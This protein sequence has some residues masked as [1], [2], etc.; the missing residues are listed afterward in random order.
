MAIKSMELE[1]TRENLL[2][3]LSLDLLDRNESVWHFACFCDAQEDRCSIA[4]DAPWGAGKTFFIRHVQ[5]LMDSVNPFTAAVT[6]EERDTIKSAFLR[7]SN[8]SDGEIELQKE[9]CVYYDAWSNDNEED[10]ILSL[11]YEIIK[12]S[13]QYVQFK[14]STDYVDVV[15]SMVDFFT[16]KNTIEFARLLKQKDLLAETKAKKEIHSLVAEFLDSLLS[17]RGDR[18]IVFIDELD[19]CKPEFAVRL[20]ERIKHYFANVRITFVFSVNLDELQHTVRR[21]YGEGFDAFRYLDRFFDYRIALPPANMTKYYQKIGLLYEHNW[22]ESVCKSVIDYYGFSLREIEKF[23]RMAKVAAHK[24]THSQ[25][26]TG[27]ADG[28]ALN[29]SLI[30]IVPIIIGLHMYNMDMYNEFITGKNPQPLL[31]IARYCG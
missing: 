15:S 17:E 1:P 26:F 18:L 10:P 12:I 9:V 21:Y 5:F 2:K 25:Y 23:Y 20:L 4:V 28:V 29:F 6:D 19:R 13:S 27:N 14:K 7:Y 30:L 8:S 16:G 31:D 24:P 3:T 22:F 11:I